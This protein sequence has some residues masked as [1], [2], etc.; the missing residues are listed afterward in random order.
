MRGVRSWFVGWLIHRRSA[1]EEP[2]TRWRARSIL[3]RLRLQR[4]SPFRSR[5][6]EGFLR[7]ID[8]YSRQELIKSLTTMLKTYREAGGRYPNLVSPRLFSES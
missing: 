3:W 1:L 4:D 8:F 5:P 6:P 2:L 7:G